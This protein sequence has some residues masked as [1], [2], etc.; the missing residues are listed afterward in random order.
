MYDRGQEKC[1]NNELLLKQ[2]R[3]EIPHLPEP[4]RCDSSQN[5]EGKKRSTHT[6]A[7]NSRARSG[8]LCFGLGSQLCR[9][10]CGSL[11]TEEEGEERGT[12]LKGLLLTSPS[13]LASLFTQ[14]NVLVIFR[15]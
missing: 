14:L 7:G 3:C 1:Q 5:S 12:N 9:E 8:G 15:I 2:W 6:W 11:R 10:V 13:R 4:A